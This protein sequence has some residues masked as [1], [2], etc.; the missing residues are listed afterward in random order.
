MNCEL[1]E[2]TW[3][4]SYLRSNLIR[5]VVIVV[6]C[7]A[8]LTWMWT[9][10]AFN[11]RNLKAN[12]IIGVAFWTALIAAIGAIVAVRH[13]GR[14]RDRLSTAI[15]NMTQG[16]L[17]FDEHQRVIVCNERYLAMYGMSTDMAKPGTT[18]REV[19][20]RRKALGSIVGDVDEFCL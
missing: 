11:F 7:S 17:L 9:A 16:L 15:D 6:V 19:I 8:V 4:I 20:S 12:A 3:L 2:M 10:G 18:L 13:L 5:T 1:L 14:E